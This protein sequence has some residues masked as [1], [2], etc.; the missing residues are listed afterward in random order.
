MQGKS[1]LDRELTE[2]KLSADSHGLT[3][4][5]ARERL[6]KYGTNTLASQKKARPLKI[7]IGQFKDI[8]VIILLI[9]TVISFLLG[10]ITDAVTITV[11]VALNALLGFIQEYRTEKTLL[12]LKNMSA[13]SAR[14]WRDGHLVSL[15]ADELVPDDVIA[16]E[17]GDKVP[18]DAVIL[19]ARALSA[20][21]SI[22]TGESVPA[23]KSAGNINDTDNRIGRSDMLYS[24][25]VITKGSGE[26][27]IIATGGAAQIGKISGMLTDIEQEETP[28]QKRLG[29]LGK[30]VALICLAVCIIVSG[31]GIL[32]G[33]PV[34]EML[35]TGITIAIAAI[36]EGLPATVTIS[37]ALAVS[38]MLKQNALVH[39]LHS[40]ETLGCSNVICT[41]KTGTI[42]E[43]KMTVKKLSCGDIN[44]SVSGNGTRKEGTVSDKN[45]N[46]QFDDSDK[47]GSF[48]M[49]IRNMILCGNSD[50]YSEKMPT[51]ADRGHK[52]GSDWQITGDPTE[53]ALL[54]AAA[55][56]GADI[57]KIR[58]AYPRTDEIPFES[59]T[60]CM[61][62]ICRS[63]EGE[64]IIFSKGAC[65]VILKRCSQININGTITFLN[66]AE[67]NEILR[68]CDDMSA[69]GLR[70]L[71]FSYKTGLGSDT[72]GM[73]FLGLCG[74]SDPPRAEAKR[75]VRLCRSAHIRTVMI[76]GDHK[77]TAAAAAKEA[78]IY[79]E[80]ELIVS[81]N[82]LEKMTDTELDEK[83]SKISVFA[84]VTPAH[85]LR[86]V[87]A[88]KRKGC[89]V[90][91]TGDGV[92]DAPAIK[93]ADIGVAMGITGTDVTRQAADMVLLD[94]NFA[95]LVSAVE[96]GR[97]IYANIRK[98][99][100][101]LLSCNIGEVLT[102]F[103]GIIMG[104]PMV[105][106]PS[107][108][109]LVNLVTDGLP[110][111]A[112][113]IEP[114]DSECM[115]KPPRKHDESFFSDGLMSKIIF[116]GILIGLCTLGCFTVILNMGAGLSA[117]RTGALL[118]LVMSQLFH[119]FECKSE[120]KNIFT[121]PYFN[122]PKL[123]LAVL[124]SAAVIFAS[125]YFPPLQAVFSTVPLNS[126]QLLTAF[127]FAI[128][129]PVIRCLFK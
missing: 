1:L 91:M 106:L 104:M 53:A 89:I 38:R 123:I 37:L 2:E 110:A 31:A 41:D 26:A 71:A 5:Q 28:L 60:R 8:M 29:E 30:I 21:E 77:N 99:V 82:E 45:G 127:G 11:I 69:E 3:T 54:I 42:T 88:F 92:N 84:R 25:T 13:P 19:S 12:A 61:S 34:F 70:V 55:K 10:E 119:V 113:G 24:G 108:I 98:F 35:M 15:S 75:A 23:H 43:N 87:R 67:K 125:I 120:T 20:D 86:I 93:E 56:S 22:L 114:T 73:I 116:R 58:E 95:T 100:R 83:L 101:Y 57:G 109:L 76:T 112:L 47:S 63:P 118:T 90:T 6:A 68:E 115:K 27:R 65:D 64:R 72:E 17:A 44:Y 59:E 52:N 33:E 14:V 4:E 96:Q 39:K 79:H 78:G 7:F 62:V 40:V 97:G 32:R 50:I 16:V 51:L 9:A 128:S 105:L 49:L 129:V 107:Q 46:V 103:L 48:P 102:M 80:G 121:V 36:P 85:K 18:A 117:A 126:T 122:N 124:F 81:G 94:D 111:I 74:M 66:D